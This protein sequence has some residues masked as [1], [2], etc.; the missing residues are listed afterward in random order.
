MRQLNE[1][2]ELERENEKYLESFSFLKS[3]IQRIRREYL[4]GAVSLAESDIDE[5]DEELATLIK[6]I[7][8]TIF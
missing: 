6:L 7:E 2:L 5:V 1:A 4:I 3:E 8:N